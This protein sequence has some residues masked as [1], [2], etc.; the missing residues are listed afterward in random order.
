MTEEKVNEF[1]K[2]ARTYCIKKH[3]WFDDDLIQDL[4]LHLYDKYDKYDETKGSFSTFAFMCFKNYL[5]DHRKQ[6]NPEILTDS[7]DELFVT[8]Y[9][10]CYKKL[11]LDQV[12]EVIRQDNILTDWFDGLTTEEIAKKHSVH[13]TT[14]SRYISKRLEEIKDEYIGG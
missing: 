9:E 14:I 2:L 4:V 12:L 11:I 7:T 8:N 13:R 10:D 1:Y 6:N 3:I 5:Y